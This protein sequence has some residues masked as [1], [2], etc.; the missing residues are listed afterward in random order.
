VLATGCEDEVVRETVCEDDIDDKD[1]VFCPDPSGK[2][3]YTLLLYSR[4]I[5]ADFKKESDYLICQAFS[6]WPLVHIY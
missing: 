3:A 1:E 6:L 5:V 4:N 2:L